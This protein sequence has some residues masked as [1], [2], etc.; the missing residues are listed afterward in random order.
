MQILLL[1]GICEDCFSGVQRKFKASD[2]YRSDFLHSLLRALVVSLSHGQ[3]LGLG[4]FILRGTTESRT[5]EQVVLNKEMRSSLLRWRGDALIVEMSGAA[6]R[7][8]EN[9]LAVVEFT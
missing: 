4:F 9:L 1:P 8:S 2:L 3:P 6:M 5:E 7:A